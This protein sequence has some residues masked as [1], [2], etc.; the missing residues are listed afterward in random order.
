MDKLELKTHIRVKSAGNTKSTI[1]FWR[2]LQDGDV[3]VVR[4]F[5]DRLTK[6]WAQEFELQN[7]RT[8]DKF[9]TGGG[10]LKNRLG[11]IKWEYA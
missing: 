4:T 5:A 9:S 1:D 6:A 7:T 3:L 8:L 2:N 11:K 10:D